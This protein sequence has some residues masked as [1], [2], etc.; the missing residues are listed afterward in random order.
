MKIDGKKGTSRICQYYKQNTN[1]G[2]MMVMAQKRNGFI[3]IMKLIF[4][5]GVVL[6]HLNAISISSQMDT[7]IMR[8]GF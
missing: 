1:I 2:G 5:F 6:N 3:D 4:C 8:C 7:I